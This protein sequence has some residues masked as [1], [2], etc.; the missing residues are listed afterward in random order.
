MKSLKYEKPGLIDINNSLYVT[1]H[2]YC[3]PGNSDVDTCWAG[4]ANTTFI[5]Q[6]GSGN[7]TNIQCWSGGL[8]TNICNEGSVATKP[9]CGPGSGT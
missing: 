3:N 8:N 1:A 5:C 6:D 4:N 2:T 9:Y 7:N